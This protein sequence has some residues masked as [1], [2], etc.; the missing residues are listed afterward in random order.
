VYPLPSRVNNYSQWT[1]TS[2]LH[3]QH[4]PHRCRRAARQIS[5]NLRK[6]DHR[7]DRLP[8]YLLSTMSRK[9]MT[10]GMQQEGAEGEGK[11]SQ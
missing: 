5:P 11:G 7:E 4:H 6:E 2:L 10:Q 9:R 3:H 1:L 8:M